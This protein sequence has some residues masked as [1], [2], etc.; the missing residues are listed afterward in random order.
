MW[1]TWVV[2]F[3]FFLLNVLSDI[4]TQR[5][6]FSNEEKK[7]LSIF[8]LSIDRKPFSISVCDSG[9]HYTLIFDTEYFSMS[10]TRGIELLGN[11]RIS[12]PCDWCF[13]NLF[14][15]LFVLTLLPYLLCL[16]LEITFSPSVELQPNHQI[17]SWRWH[18]GNVHVSGREE[19]PVIASN[20][21]LSRTESHGLMGRKGA[22]ETYPSFH[23]LGTSVSPENMM[24]WILVDTSAA[25]LRIFMISYPE[26]QIRR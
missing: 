26:R 24:K 23:M 4:R 22:W 18:V 6:V 20:T 19:A 11:Y 7:L 13:L 2:F 9:T 5:G 25:T 16:W 17:S 3:F 21:W 12:S 10:Y 14:L 1:K 15:S 8:Y